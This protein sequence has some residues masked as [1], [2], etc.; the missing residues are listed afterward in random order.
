MGRRKPASQ[1]GGSPK[2]RVRPVAG[3]TRAR[4]GCGKGK[5]EG[6]RGD[7]LRTREQV[8]A[9][10]PVR[11]CVLGAPPTRVSRQKAEASF[12]SCPRCWERLARLAVMLDASR[13]GESPSMER[14]LAG[15]FFVSISAS[16]REHR[17]PPRIARFGRRVNYG[18][19][20]H[21]SSAILNYRSVGEIFLARSCTFN[22]ERAAEND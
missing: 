8:G 11:A 18:D 13:R 10:R 14:V 9:T 3:R 17:W 5:R 22:A 7:G 20:L 15:G 1:G 4:D 12:P 6:G 2:K 21:A 19:W 16:R